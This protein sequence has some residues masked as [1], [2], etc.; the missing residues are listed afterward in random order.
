MSFYSSLWREKS[1]ALPNTI[2]VIYGVVGQLLG[3]G[4][5]L[6]SGWVGFCV[7]VL[8]CAH[9]LVIC[10]YLV[11]EAAH[12]TLFNTKKN[13]QRI[14]NIML[15]MAG[16]GYASFERVRHMHMRHHQDRADVSCFNYQ[17][18]LIKQPKIIQNLVSVLE[19]LYIPAVELIMHAQV[20]LR[21][22]IDDHLKPHRRRVIL[23][24][25]SRMAFFV[26][27]FS[28][29]PWIL[30]GYAMAYC[31]MLQVLFIADAFAHTYESFF[32][33]Q[34]NDPVPSNDR[35][36]LYDVTHTYSNLIS[37]RWPWLN[38]MN[39]NFGYHT[40]HHEKASV[41]W[42]D[43]PAFHQELYGKGDHEHILPYK[44]LFRTLH[45]NRLKRVYIDDYGDVGQ[46]PNRADSFVGA[47]GVSFLSIV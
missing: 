4:L 2:A 8:L 21:P 44:A 46:G 19:W 38:V 45:K 10:A 47:H 25:V 20:I 41:G 16:S 31:I 23:V 39:L 3:L 26:L 6:Q 17:N 14:G 15:W 7:G 33:K 43:L 28:L 27:L 35:D 30:L 22:F 5:M 29:S 18:F 42:H 11:H 37:Q 32:V 9:S 1:G 24:G 34:L 40:A 12:M 36:R 13:N